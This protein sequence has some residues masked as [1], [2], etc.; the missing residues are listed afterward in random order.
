MLTCER[1]LAQLDAYYDGGLD[2]I[3]KQRLE[4]HGDNC[5][6]CRHVAL[7]KY[8]E[9]IFLS[10]PTFCEVDP[11]FPG[12]SIPCL[13]KSALQEYRD[14]RL[15]FTQT[16]TEYVREHLAECCI[17]DKNFKELPAKS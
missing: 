10:R 12:C 3:Q 16:E 8:D 7:A 2:P 1:F 14:H 11:T 4:D 6:E 13:S 17:C 9:R 5:L 15:G